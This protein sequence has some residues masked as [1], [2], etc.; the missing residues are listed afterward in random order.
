MSVDQLFTLQKVYILITLPLR[1]HVTVKVLWWMAVFAVCFHIWWFYSDCC[2]WTFRGFS[3]LLLAVSFRS[4][5]RVKVISVTVDRWL[6]T[7]VKVISITVGLWLSWLVS[8]TL[9]SCQSY[10]RHDRSATCDLCQNHQHSGRSMILVTHVRVISVMVDPWLWWLMSKS[11]ASQ[12]Q[13]IKSC[14]SLWLWILHS[15]HVET[16]TSFLQISFSTTKDLS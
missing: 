2:W 15:G 3:I 7:H 6:M 10:R 9:D 13:F 12:C 11:S 4:V 16:S 1:L 8:V 14:V 5:T